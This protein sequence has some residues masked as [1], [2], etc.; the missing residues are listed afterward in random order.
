MGGG[1]VKLLVVAD[2]VVEVVFSVIRPTIISE[3]SNITFAG[4][5]GNI[6]DSRVIHNCLCIIRST[7]VTSPGGGAGGGGTSVLTVEGDGGSGGGQSAAGGLEVWST[8]G[9]NGSVSPDQG[10]GNNEEGPM[11]AGGGGA[12]QAVELGRD[13][14]GGDDY[15]QYYWNYNSLCWRR[16]WC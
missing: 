3:G 5:A 4:G 1:S 11:N 12:G 16:W 2:L 14:D 8:G 7:T 10:W 6:T 9:S 13:R 15:L